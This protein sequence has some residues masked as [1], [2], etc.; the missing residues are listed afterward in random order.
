MEHSHNAMKM[1]LLVAIISNVYAGGAT[2]SLTPSSEHTID[3]EYQ[4]SIQNR[5]QTVGKQSNV[6][7]R[8][9]KLPNRL[10]Y[11]LLSYRI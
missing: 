11:R 7:G 5:D 3:L 4:R 6:P 10:I 2:L 9:G 1:T 8:N